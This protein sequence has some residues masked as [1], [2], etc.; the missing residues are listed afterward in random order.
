ML[1]RED[2]GTTEEIVVIREEVPEIVAE[3]IVSNELF[4]S[5]VDGEVDLYC[6]EEVQFPSDEEFEE[7]HSA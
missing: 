7:A 1:N 5:I 6:Y 4:D 3:L 2:P